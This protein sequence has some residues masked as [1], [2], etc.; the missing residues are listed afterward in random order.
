MKLYEQLCNELSSR[1][2]QGYYQ[3]GDKLPS[4]RM[5]SQEHGVSIST[6]QEAYRLLEANGL[7]ESRPK[8]GYYVQRKTASPTLPEISRPVQRPLEVSQWELVLELLDSHEREGLVA[9]GRGMPDVSATTLKPLLKILSDLNRHSDLRSLSY[10]NL[11]GSDELRLQ[12]ARLCVDSGCRLHPD[13]IVVTTGCQE[14]LSCSMRVVTQ[15][16]DVVAVDSPSFYGSMQTIKALGLKA[17]EI[18]THP[19]TG[20][21]LE[22]LELALEQWPVKAIQVTPIC[23]N[24]L[25]YTMPDD[26]KQRLLALAQQYDLPI[27]E[28]DIYGDLAYQYPRPR[29]IKSYDDDGRVMLCSSVSKTLA[30]GLRVGWVAPGRYGDL[31]LHMKYVSTASTATLPQRAVAEFIA[32][33][34]YERH[35]RKMRAQYQRGRDRMIEWIERYF[36][37]ATRISYPQGGFLLWV[38]LPEG[39]DSVKLNKKLLQLGIGIA[40]GV[41]FS[42][43]GKYR[44]CFRI[45]YTDV[46]GDEVQSAVKI[47]GEQAAKMLKESSPQ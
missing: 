41:L 5:M 37:T 35:L 47:I 29:T 23:N 44:N 31:L 20:V 38:E 6:V 18:P 13:D 1:I 34:G 42:A 46:A 15:P 19:E 39:F 30:P 27:I 21:S 2:Q 8:S 10:D 32:Q 3:A 14:A 12:I 17:L 11:R 43:S 28:D 45:N 7:A 22:A 36:P 25:G 26:R 4:I 9:L 24:P 33:G 16:G 40:P